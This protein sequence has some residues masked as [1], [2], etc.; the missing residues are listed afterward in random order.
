MR[1]GAQAIIVPTMDLADLAR[2]QYE[3]HAR[4][5]PV[6]AAE[7]GV[8]IFRVASS[9]ISQC[10]NARGQVTASAPM[11]GD[12][13]MISGFL[14]LKD[15]GTLPLD[16]VIAPLSTGVTGLFIGWLALASSGIMKRHQTQKSI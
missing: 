12:E 10:V 2:H 16:R 9:G 8:P 1:L 4:V 7:Y 15:A 14:D 5:A 6:R 11:P 3:M 13:A